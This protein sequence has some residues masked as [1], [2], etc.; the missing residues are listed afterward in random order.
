[1][2]L[3][4]FRGRDLA[5]VYRDVSR[6]LGDD[7]M[8][9]HSRVVRE[10]GQ[11]YIE[12]VAVDAVEIA[13]FRRQLAPPVPSV[14]RPGASRQE[15]PYTVALVGPTGGGKTLTAQKLVVH[16]EAFGGKRAGLLALDPDR[17]GAFDRLLHFA[18][19]NDLDIEIAHDAKGLRTAQRRLAS[20]DVIIV[21]TP[22]GAPRSDRAS[23]RAMLRELTPDETHLV[24][25]ATTR[26]DLAGAIRD[27]AESLGVTHALLTKLDEVPSDANV[28]MLA[29]ELGLPAR[30]IT[31]G[32]RPTTDLRS[33]APTIISA[34]EVAPEEQGAFA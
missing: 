28:A 24:F 27:D 11:T 10:G 23:W 26:Y 3:E 31:D 32:Q 16:D 1:M 19:T 14:L 29:S 18:D 13:R 4:R 34:F 33:A 5:T 9:A 30:W 20:C 7:A 22:G 2:R 25:P 8:I 21:D 6:T 17:A 15:R 12:V